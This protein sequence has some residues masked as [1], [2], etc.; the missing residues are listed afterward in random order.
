MTKAGYVE[1]LIELNDARKM[2]ERLGGLVAMSLAQGNR[3]AAS[4]NFAEFSRWVTNALRAAT[5]ALRY[6]DD[7]RKV[8][9]R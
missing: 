2:V 3:H 6:A 1:A 7:G 5:K 8:K 9:G 4:N